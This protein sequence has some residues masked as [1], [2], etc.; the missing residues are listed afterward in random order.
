[1]PLALSDARQSVCGVVLGRSAFSGQ[2]GESGYQG[3]ASYTGRANTGQ[4]LRTYAWPVLRVSVHDLGLARGQ[5]DA[6]RLFGE[7]LGRPVACASV[8]P[9][10]YSR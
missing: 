7:A 4:F 10:L 1:M 5:V 6:G 3:D 9:N 8:P 2:S